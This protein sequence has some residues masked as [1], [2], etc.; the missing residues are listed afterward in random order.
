MSHVMKS[1]THVLKQIHSVVK[2]SLDPLQLANQPHIAVKD[3]IIVLLHRAYTHLEEAGRA[4]S[5]V[6]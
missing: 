2:P 5:H 6:L 4:V 1:E 3:A